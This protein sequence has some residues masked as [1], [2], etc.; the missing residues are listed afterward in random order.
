[1]IRGN[2]YLDALNRWGCIELLD[3]KYGKTEYSAVK[4]VYQP[5]PIRLRTLEIEQQETEG[6][7]VWNDDV[8]QSTQRKPRDR[9]R[10]ASTASGTEAESL[11]KQA[12][13]KAGGERLPMIDFG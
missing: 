8:K 1:M 2:R 12:I 10:S 13:E 3:A 11:V 7:L 9:H 5:L 4:F 6:Q